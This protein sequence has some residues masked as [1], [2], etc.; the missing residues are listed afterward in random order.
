MSRGLFVS[1]LGIDG[2]GKSSLADDLVGWC[3]QGGR[4]VTTISWK[5]LVRAPGDDHPLP[6]LRNIWVEIF[7]LI[8]AGA[9]DDAGRP[10]PLPATFGE[11]MELGG[12]QHLR[13]SPASPPEGSGPFVATL[14]ELAGNVLLHREVIDRAVAN[15]QIVIQ[16]SYGYKHAFKELLLC[17][18]LGSAPAVDLALAR[19]FLHDFFGRALA[20][21][22]G[23]HVRG[24]PALA[25]RW[26]LGQTG[27][28]SAFESFT[29]AGEDPHTSFLAMQQECADD[30]DRFAERHGWLR[31]DIEDA[32]R[33]VNRQRALAGL[34]D[35]PFAE[36]L[37][38]AG[39]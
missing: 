7:R 36:V 1:L 19:S 37:S 22:V 2:I 27:Q 29:L 25:L 30:F 23:I 35:S 3:E 11:L 33:E 31:L 21:D 28:T 4:S 24:T 15:G 34:R 16:E 5:Q 12:S 17:A 10:L 8:Y 9:R 26:R 39:V 13:D 14:L 18:R 32:P 6:S 38:A 20:P